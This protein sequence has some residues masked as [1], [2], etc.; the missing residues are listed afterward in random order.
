MWQI[1]LGFLLALVILYILGARRPSKLEAALKLLH[2]KEVY[3][4]KKNL[5]NAQKQMEAI[6]EK[7]KQ[8]LK[9]NFT[10]K[11][12]IELKDEWI[13]A[14]SAYGGL[15]LKT[16]D[17]F[18]ILVELDI[19]HGQSALYVTSQMASADMSGHDY[20]KV[21][22]SSGGLSE[23]VL[24]EGT[25]FHSQKVLY[26]FQSILQKTVNEMEEEDGLA[27]ET[28][29]NT[30]KVVQKCKGKKGEKREIKL[31]ILPCVCSNK[32]CYIAKPDTYDEKEGTL[33]KW[34]VVLLSKEKEK[35]SKVT[36]Y[37]LKVLK[38]AIAFCKK[39]ETLAWID[40]YHL[41]TVFLHML[42]T[43]PGS[44]KETDDYFKLVL[45]Y[46]L[47]YL[48]EGCLPDYFIPKRNLFLNF[49]QAHPKTMENATARLRFILRSGN[50]EMVKVIKPPKLRWPWSKPIH[51][52]QA[53][54][55]HKAV[56][57]EVWQK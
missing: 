28:N 26:G 37:K 16:P 10:E 44:W 35:M 18:E 34:K 20:I 38:L 15:K 53:M 11:Y 8:K 52:T 23:M 17:E 13:D 40:P 6:I 5:Q 55:S 46:L 48:R 3:I 39:D 50:D 54:I 19:W 56:K 31:E 29:G 47:D 32:R 30:I 51:T 43:V 24:G 21:S 7:L 9:D 36:Q 22:G 41:K 42:D 25:V 33:G 49:A 14:G 1:C 4:S 2:K 45:E 27:V 12:S 57:L